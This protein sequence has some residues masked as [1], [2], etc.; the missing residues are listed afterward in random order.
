MKEKWRR[1]RKKEMKKDFLAFDL[2]R[3]F[4]FFG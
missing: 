3:I 1:R 2:F 4:S